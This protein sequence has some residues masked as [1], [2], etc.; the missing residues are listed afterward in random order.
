MPQLLRSDAP[1]VV[2]LSSLIRQYGHMT[3]ATDEAIAAI[4]RSYSRCKLA[5][6]IFAREP[7]QR[8]DWNH[9][10]CSQSPRIR[11]S[12]LTKGRPGQAGIV[13]QSDRR[14]T[15]PAVYRK[16]GTDRE[17]PHRALRSR[18]VSNTRFT[19]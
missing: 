18:A 10:P 9:W 16:R 17:R 14:S 6:R 1:G 8:S 7:Q 4:R 15:R 12:D 13:R 3:P 11:A 2:S 5:M 19:G